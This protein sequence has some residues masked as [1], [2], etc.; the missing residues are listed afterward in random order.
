MDNE[1]INGQ[2]IIADNLNVQLIVS[3]NTSIREVYV[4]DDYIYIILLMVMKMLICI[5]LKLMERVG[6]NYKTIGK[7]NI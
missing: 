3:E 1:D 5:E 2:S 4:V 6:K 7:R